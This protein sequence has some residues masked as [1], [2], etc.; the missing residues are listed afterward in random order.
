MLTPNSIWTVGRE[1][2]NLVTRSFSGLLMAE[3]IKNSELFTLA[4]TGSESLLL[5]NLTLLLLREEMKSSSPNGDQPTNPLS[6]T[7]TPKRR[8]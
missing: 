3:I 2:K 6:S 7:T 5:T 8:L 1:N 4:R